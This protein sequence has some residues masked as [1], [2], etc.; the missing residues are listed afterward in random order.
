VNAQRYFSL[1]L[2]CAL[3]TACG[4]GGSSTAAIPP[5]PS[6]ADPGA[7]A[8][9]V[10]ND[11]MRV[12]DK[13]TIRLSGVPDPDYIVEVQL[14]ASGVISMPLLT[15]PFQAV[16]RTPYDVSSE[17]VAAYKAEKIYTN[18]NV[19]I[20]SEDRFVNIGGDVRNPMRVNY[21]ADLTLLGAINACGGFD[22]Y[23][24]RKAVRIIRGQQVM[25]VNAVA[26]SK[27]AGADP[28][29][30]PGDQVYVPRTVF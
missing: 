22:E 11:V 23:A 21:T 18:P 29:L 16:G 26:A 9:S 24:N 10:T 15:H 20:I 3:L 25:Q 28:A 5:A 1:L 19:T 17:I 8:P 7:V 12:G 14:P 2:C 4:G 27:T 13:I 6:A 30:Y